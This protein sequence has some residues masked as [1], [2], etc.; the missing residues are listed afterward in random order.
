MG[1][2]LIFQ[3]FTNAVDEITMGILGIVLSMSL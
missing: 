1:A 3:G 2:V